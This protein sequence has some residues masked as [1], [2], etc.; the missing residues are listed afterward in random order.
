MLKVHTGTLAEQP[1][2]LLEAFR[3]WS[4]IGASEADPRWITVPAG[5]RT[6]F[7]SIPRPMTRRVWPLLPP[8]GRSGKAAVIHHWLCDEQPHSVDHRMAADIFN[9]A[10]TVLGEPALRRAIMASNL[11][12]GLSS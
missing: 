7:A 8:V 6:D 2:E 5:Y 12:S 3:Y 10:M 1:F 9:E 4:T 11:A